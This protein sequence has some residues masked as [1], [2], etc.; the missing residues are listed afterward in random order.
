LHKENPITLL[1]INTVFLVTAALLITL[2]YY[3]QAKNIYVGLLITELV[4]IPLP[5]F[6]YIRWKGISAKEAFRFNGISLSTLWKCALITLC[7]YPVGLFLNLLGNLI[8]DMM[9]EPL[10]LPVPVAE[11]GREYI[12]NILVI[13]L[14]AGVGEEL[15]F[16]GFLLKG[17]EWLGARKA[18]IYSAILFGIFHFNIQNFIGP[19]FLGIVFA[20]MSI[21]TGSVAAPVVGHFINNAVSVTFMFIASMMTD[22]AVQG[23]ESTFTPGVV[24]SSVA[25]WGILAL[26]GGT[27][28][29][30][31]FRGLEGR[32]PEVVPG[33]TYV[34]DFIP[35]MVTV[36]V[37]VVICA[38]QLMLIMG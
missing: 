10:P 3:L 4:I 20:V 12:K 36:A 31:L 13:A 37:F 9:G 7:V 19:A 11:S 5:A 34:T 25:F 14:A 23:V 16:R 29:L 18:V 24:A 38:S 27:A 35:V 30:R 22:T 32:R 8:L 28:A 6:M 1:G 2:G 15:F 33:K 17:Y 26:A 21:K